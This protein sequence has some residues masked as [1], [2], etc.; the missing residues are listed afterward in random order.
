MIALL[1]VFIG[2][3]I[4]G[5]PV[6]YVLG[7]TALAHVAIMGES[8]L[9]MMLPQ[10][11]FAAINNFSL[12]AIPLFILAGELMSFG[13]ITEKLTDMMRSFVGHIKGGLAYTTVLVGTALG[14]LVG[15]ANASA[16]LLGDVLYDEIKKD[17]YSEGFS[18][19]LIAATSILG[20]I[21]PPS[22]VFIVYGVA[23]SVSVAKMFF[24]GIVPGVLLAVSY[25]FIIGYSVRH[26]QKV[27]THPRA[28]LRQVGIS[29]LKAI[30]A[31]L[32]PV[33][34]LGGIL[35][36]ITTPTEAAATAC[37]AAIII[38]AFVYRKLKWKHLPHVLERT[39]VLSAA[40]M[41]IVGMANMMGWTLA[42]DQVPQMIA[43]ALLSIT[44]NRYLLLLL[45]N[46]LLLLV[47][48]VMETIA[49][50]VIL[51]PVFLPVI[52]AVGID[53]LH[54]GIVVC[55]NL[56]I[57]LLTP[58]VGTT[59]FTTVMV[60]KVPTSA[61]IKNIWPW[62]IVQFAVLLLITYLPGLVTF[63]PNLLLS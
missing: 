51:V 46:L 45:I 61:L 1:I 4:L 29:V 3:I 23:A 63:L 36:G 41:F 17:G 60:T 12:M 21:I 30:P 7:S 55:V 32:V 33:I 2:T 42:L 14:A 40:T 50:I 47:G 59:L 20:P 56:I 49:A 44:E 37:V 43:S 26:K 57:G 39:G 35:G 62:L 22:M 18:A 19:S 24:A 58:P 28:T 52:T 6:A 9:F 10:R 25:F 31:L 11:M 13:G 54:F 27:K 53:P 16:A 48:M 8:N 34:I 38:G 5:L 15:S